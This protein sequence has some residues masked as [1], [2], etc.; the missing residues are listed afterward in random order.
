MGEGRGRIHCVR[1]DVFSARR[2]WHRLERLVDGRLRSDQ[3]A[4]QR[5]QERRRGKTTKRFSLGCP[6]FDPKNYVP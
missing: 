3:F 1:T 2:V 6:R 5:I 4:L